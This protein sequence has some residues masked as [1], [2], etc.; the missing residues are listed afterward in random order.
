MD[1]PA[2]LV[3]VGRVID[4]WRLDGGIKVAPWSVDAG[5]L[6]ASRRWCLESGGTS[7]TFDVVN[8]RL[9][10]S[11]IAARLSGIDDRDAAEALKGATVSVARG[12]FPAT[13]ANEFYWVDLVG[14]DVVNTEGD[15]LGRVDRLI[16]NGVHPVLVVRDDADASERMIP[17]VDAVVPSV[18]LVARRVLVDWQR[19]Y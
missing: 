3:P 7:R 12:D 1:T 10:G 9:H 2:D 11:A 13:G 19:D 4:A 8:A 16:D 15:V 6:L 18:D 5:A 17:F 14:L